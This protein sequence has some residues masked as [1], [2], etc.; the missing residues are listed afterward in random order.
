MDGGLLFGLAV[1]FFIGR[2]L[3]KVAGGVKEGLEAAR[4]AG[5]LPREGGARPGR[6][7][8]T[9]E[10]LLAEMRG[11]L[12]TARQAERPVPIRP[13]PKRLPLGMR[14][15]NPVPP[16]YPAEIEVAEEAWEERGSL[17]R[18]VEV[19]SFD[20]GVTG[21]RA[22][23]AEVD[24][25]TEVAEIAR[26]R[27]EV[28]ER[29]NQAITAADHRAFDERIRRRDAPAPVAGAP[30]LPLREAMLWREILGPPVALR[31]GDAED[32]G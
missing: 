20:E 3:F 5:T 10:E 2:T 18:E 17:E 16:T 14:P 29:R 31:R 12:E 24:Y 23:A 11:Q 30:R 4:R 28:A 27:R 13:T 25:D 1:L 21:D 26:K 19:V 9:M 32:Q 7:P 6:A 22:M 8:Q 15:A